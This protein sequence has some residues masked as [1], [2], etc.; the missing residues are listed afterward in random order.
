MTTK[1]DSVTIV[2]F[3]LV[4]KANAYMLLLLFVLFN[5]ADAKSPDDL[6]QYYLYGSN[7]SFPVIDYHPADDAP[8]FLYGVD[9]GPR[10][11]EFYFHACHHVRQRK[12]YEDSLTK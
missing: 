8:D 4:I 10:V 1:Q 9:Q 6:P 12:L 5:P 7:D 3:M 2:G 11:V